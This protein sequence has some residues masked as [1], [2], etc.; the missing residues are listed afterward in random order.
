MSTLT[1]S[2]KK[3]SFWI[4]NSQS[5]HAQFIRNHPFRQNSGWDNWSLQPG[6]EREMIELY[7][8]EMNFKLPEEIYELY[9][10]H[11]G[12]FV[13]GD[14]ANPVY[15]GTF[16]EGFDRVFN[17]EFPHFPI[18]FGDACY[19]AIDKVTDNSTSSPI[20]LY[21]GRDEVLGVYA[22]SLTN[23]MK[24]VV[25]C[26]EN[27]DVISIQSSIGDIDRKKDYLITDIYRKHGVIGQICGLWR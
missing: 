19:Y 15:F 8:E 11:N 1:Q 7:V 3:F 13:I 6:L 24:A 27:Y 4:E 12:K 25:E 26:A 5:S 17:D 18:F 21:D 20:R 10:W 16:E 2:L 23:L 9:Q 22:P 14:Y